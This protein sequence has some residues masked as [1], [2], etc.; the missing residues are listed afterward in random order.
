MQNI[1]YNKGMVIAIIL[2]SIFGF[3]I[4][5]TF[6]LCLGLYLYT[7]YSPKK[8]QSDDYKL[9][10]QIYGGHQDTVKSMIAAIK[11]VPYEDIYVTS[12]DK[13]KLH[14]KLYDQKSDTVAILCHGYR[15]TP[16]RD[17]SG[18]AMEALNFGYNVILIDERA[19]CD[20][21]GH[22]ITF[23]VRE[24]K[25]VLS[26]VKYAR[27]RFGQD[28]K[29]VLIGISMGGATVLM[30]MDKVEGNV[31]VIADCPFTSP[32]NMIKTVIRKLKLPV[33]LFYPLVNLS[34]LIFA[35]TSLNKGSAEESVSK[36]NHP[37]LIIHGDKDTVVPY[38][39]SEELYKKHPDKIRY[40]LFPG[41]DHG[42]SYIVDKP[43]Y[44]RILKE[45]LSK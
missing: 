7:F 29:I 33:W 36:T 37:I 42:M 11:A 2:G 44:Q 43:R 28:I 3:L 1:I 23:G 4:I 16:Y 19:H 38:T 20:S 9:D 21:K 30:A 41:A 31:K 10:N 35:H 17:F 13:L 25:D 18:G 45:F 12:F 5:F 14:A 34:L 24:Q 15:G 8:F 26:W 6:F 39:M 32:A 27:D 40:E 22:S